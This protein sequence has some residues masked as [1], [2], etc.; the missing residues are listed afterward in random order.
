MHRKAASAT[1]DSTDTGAKNAAS[2][3]DYLRLVETRHKDTMAGEPISFHKAQAGAR[4]VVFV[5]SI[6]EGTR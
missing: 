4:P 1:A 5:P 2:G 6:S 3:I